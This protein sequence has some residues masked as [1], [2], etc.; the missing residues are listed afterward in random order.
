MTHEELTKLLTYDPKTGFFIWL[1]SRPGIKGGR[2]AGCLSGDG[3]IRIRVNGVLYLASRL[4]WFYMTRRWP[5]CQIDHK[6]LNRSDNSWANLREVTAS[7][8]SMN[9]GMQSHNTSGHKGVYFCNTK[10]RWIA[11]IQIEYV[12]RH[13]GSFDTAEEAA[14]ARKEW[15]EIYHEEFGRAA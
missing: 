7:Q 14:E 12:V 11:K 5:Y 15:I 4:A 6:N 10:R 9:T 3:Y 1:Y 2:R 13:L 8:N